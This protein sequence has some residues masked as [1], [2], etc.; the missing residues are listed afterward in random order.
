VQSLVTA[1]LPNGLNLQVL[2][3]LDGT[4]DEYHIPHDSEKSI[5]IGAKVKARILYQLSSS[6]PPKLGLSLAN[7]VVN[8]DVCRHGSSEASQPTLL[9]AFPIG[10]ILETVEVRRVEPERGLVMEVAPGVEGFVH[11]RTYPYEP[12]GS[13]TLSRSRKYPMN[14]FPHFPFQLVRG[15][16]EHFIAPGLQVVFPWT[17]SCS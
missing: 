1:V 6:T 2:G 4:V 3:F 12:S 15:R 10:T 5:Q 16:L 11:V 9:E 7:H 8:L 17:D 14:M 13:L